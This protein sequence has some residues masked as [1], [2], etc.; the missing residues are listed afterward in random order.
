MDYHMGWQNIWWLA[1]SDYLKLLPILGLAFYIAFLPHQN[2][3]YPVHIDEWVHL[4]FSKAMLGAGSSTFTDPF[5]GQGITGL[6]FNLEAGFHLFWGVFQRVSG[7]SW[8]TIFRYF[9]S[10]IFMIIYLI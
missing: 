10:I 4:T 7:I 8:L 1:K 2:Y 6:G 5:S 9:P 3:P